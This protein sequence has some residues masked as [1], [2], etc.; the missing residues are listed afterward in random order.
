MAADVAAR[1]AAV[2]VEIKVFAG[3]RAAEL[4]RQ[5]ERAAGGAL[6]DATRDLGVF[7]GRVGVFVDDDGAP[8]DVV[9]G[10][11]F[12]VEG[13]GRQR[14]RDSWRGGGGQSMHCT[15]VGVGGCCCCCFVV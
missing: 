8:D 1:S 4:P 12:E 2:H 7:R 9:E 5:R 13:A 14:K 15:H 11:L 3:F 6:D 10:V